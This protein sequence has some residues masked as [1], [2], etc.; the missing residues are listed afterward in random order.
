[1]PQNQLT[2]EVTDEPGAGG[3]NHCYRITWPLSRLGVGTVSTT[4]NFQNGSIKEAGVNGITQEVLLAILIDRLRS[5]QAGPFPCN[6]NEA[7]LTACEAALFYLK[8]RTL[9]RLHR[10]VEGE[11][12]A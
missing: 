7:A 6:E 4:I 5:F 1:M 3:A 9:E 11:T 8:K 2:I 10:G 12:K